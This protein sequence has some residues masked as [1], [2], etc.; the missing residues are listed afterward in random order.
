MGEE[1][2]R[3]AMGGPRGLYRPSPTSG[4]GGRSVERTRGEGEECVY[5]SA[6]SANGLRAI[7]SREISWRRSSERI[8]DGATH[9]KRQWESFFERSCLFE[10]E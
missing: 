5:V 2:G 10:S 4:R 8:R 3:A 1:E 9:D 7:S 6:G